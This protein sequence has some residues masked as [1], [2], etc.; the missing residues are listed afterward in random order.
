M[1]PYDMQETIKGRGNAS[2]EYYKYQDIWDVGANI[3]NYVRRKGNHCKVHLIMHILISIIEIQMSVCN[4]YILYYIILY[5]YAIPETWD[6]CIGNEKAGVYRGHKGSPPAT[7]SH[8]AGQR[9]KS[10]GQGGGL[11]CFLYL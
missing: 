7:L 11:I 10:K 5:I 6:M 3:L 1:E 2:L 8:D 4:I 9:F